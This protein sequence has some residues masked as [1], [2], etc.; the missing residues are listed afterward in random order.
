[1]DVS[2]VEE[3]FLRGEWTQALRDSHNLLKLHQAK[4]D[5]ALAASTL[6]STDAERLLSVYLQAIFEL[7]R[8]EDVDTAT[9]IVNSFRPLPGGIA[10]YYSRFLVAMNQRAMALE[11]LNDLLAS[12]AV[13]K[14]T[15]CTIE[16]YI[17]AV[18]L[19]ALHVLLP[20]EGQKA[21]QKF[22]TKDR[23]LNDTF[24]R[25]FLQEIQNFDGEKKTVIFGKSPLTGQ[26][27][28]LARNSDFS[29]KS[30]GSTE[31]H[32][33]KIQDDLSSYA[34]IGGTVVALAV[35]AAGTLVYRRKIQETVGTMM[36]AVSKG[37][38]DAKYVLFEGRMGYVNNGIDLRRNGSFSFKSL[39][40][41]MENDARRLKY[42]ACCKIR[43]MEASLADGGTK[44]GSKY[45]SS[46]VL[47]VVSDRFAT[48]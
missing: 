38:I 19:L 40:D 36:N 24:K 28:E 9:A 22:V 43:S 48:M 31:P 13:N 2:E 3:A 17:H 18:E 41:G 10:L 15:R 16:E 30:S 47:V 45:S 11:S 6:L 1:M 29:P 27:S 7:D 20:G 12:Y 39:V 5:Q 44:S 14:A 21:A 4:Q 37:I 26:N 23:V 34:M 42:D 35:T 33:S 25:T 46:A 32:N 8:S